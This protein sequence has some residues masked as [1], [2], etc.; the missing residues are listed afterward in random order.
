MAGIERVWEGR[1]A[2]LLASGPSLTPAQC[3]YV[4]RSH[5]RRELVVAGVNDTYRRYPDLDLL[6]AADR[7]WWG[8][9]LGDVRRLDIPELCC[10]V[11]SAARTL[12]LR[13]VPGGGGH[14]LSED[15]ARIHFGGNSGFQLFNLAFLRGAARI[16]LLGYDYTYG[17]AGEAHFFGD[18]PAP[19][20]N[21]PEDMSAWVEAYEN[22]E[23]VV[24][25]AGVSVINCSPTSTIPCFPKLSLFDVL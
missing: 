8:A 11:K 13:Y 25:R 14:R 3:E 22:S 10:P 18:H 2:V 12:R 24:R 9:H 6:Y 19:L 23:S 20:R 21:P 7:Q 17:T 15:P 16:L 1:T 4:S 5:R